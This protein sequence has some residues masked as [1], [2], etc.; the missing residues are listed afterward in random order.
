MGHGLQME[1]SWASGAATGEGRGLPRPAVLWGLPESPDTGHVQEEGN[2]PARCVS[3]LPH[4]AG[5]Q[6]RLGWGRCLLP[7]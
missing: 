1:P 3:W 5:Y 7:A 4:A 6:T 2:H